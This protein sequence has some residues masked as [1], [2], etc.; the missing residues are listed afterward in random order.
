MKAL[1]PLSDPRDRVHLARTQIV[2]KGFLDSA[3]VELIVQ[4]V[5]LV[6]AQEENLLDLAPAQFGTV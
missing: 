1:Q 3:E 6:V 2:Q 4:L 5:V